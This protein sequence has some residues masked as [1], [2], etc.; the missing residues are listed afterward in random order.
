MERERQRD[1]VKKTEGSK[2]G[3]R[4]EWRKAGKEKIKTGEKEEKKTLWNERRIK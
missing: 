1:R 4:K 2:K 3:K